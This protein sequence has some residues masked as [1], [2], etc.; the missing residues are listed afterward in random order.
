MFTTLMMKHEHCAEV[1]KR[2]LDL[3]S[4]VDIVG[5]AYGL[6]EHSDPAQTW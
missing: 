4:I 3:T 5:I 6:Y 1:E 2:P